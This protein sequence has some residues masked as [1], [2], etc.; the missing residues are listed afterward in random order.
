MLRT[1]FSRKHS[2][3]ICLKVTI[4]YGFFV[5]NYCNN[6]Y[7]RNM[8]SFSLREAWRFFSFFYDSIFFSHKVIGHVLQNRQN[9]KINSPRSIFIPDQSDYC[10]IFVACFSQQ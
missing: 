6:G 8:T 5:M 10:L 1:A 7:Q 9:S 3:E 4:P 2:K